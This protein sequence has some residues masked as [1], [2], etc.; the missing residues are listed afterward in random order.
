MNRLEL[1]SD[2]DFIFS[3]CPPVRVTEAGTAS[4]RMGS[5]TH[6]RLVYPELPRRISPQA[7]VR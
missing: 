7:H 4:V 5:R 1:A 6:T 3:W 2:S